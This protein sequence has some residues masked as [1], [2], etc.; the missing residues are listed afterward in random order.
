M[1]V[2]IGC[3]RSGVLRR[4]FRAV[5]FDTWSCDLA[6]A[7][8][9]DATHI[10]GDVLE[11]V[12]D[13]WHLVVAHPECVYLCGSGLHWTARGLRPLEKTEAAVDFV[14]TL[15]DAA[16]HV[17]HLAIENPRGLLTRVL[18]APDQSIHPYQFGDDASKETCLWLRGLPTL[19]PTRYVA[20]RIVNGRAR[21]ANQTDSGQNRLGQSA[22]RSAKRARTYP[23]IAAAM[24]DQWGNAVRCRQAE[25]NFS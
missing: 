22:T 6:E 8:D 10:V 2:L 12:R 23:G 5:G 4:A 21:W 20:P 24:A 13:R 19:R 1:R 25:V 7:D 14:T 11:V 18:R 17:P 3:E 15:I 9:G 16:R